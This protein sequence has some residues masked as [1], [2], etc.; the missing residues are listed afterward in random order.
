MLKSRFPANS[1]VHDAVTCKAEWHNLH[2]VVAPFSQGCAPL[3]AL[4]GPP[5]PGITTVFLQVIDNIDRVK[6]RDLIS[7]FEIV[8][9]RSTP[10]CTAFP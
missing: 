7:A 6:A 9:W 2:M 5:R 8:Q 4:W 10:R 1:K 3:T